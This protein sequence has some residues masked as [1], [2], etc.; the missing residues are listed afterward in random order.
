M[1]STV[2]SDQDCTTVTSDQDCT[3]VTSDQDCIYVLLQMPGLHFVCSV[4]LGNI[5]NGED[6]AMSCCFWPISRE[7]PV[8]NSNDCNFIAEYNRTAQW[9]VAEGQDCTAY[10]CPDC[11]VHC[12]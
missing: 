4:D 9:P 2:T 8:A 10:C 11:T 5:T 3:T 12:C 1:Y 6:C 7:C